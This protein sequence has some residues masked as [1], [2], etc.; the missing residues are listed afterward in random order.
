[1]IPKSEF[2]LIEWSEPQRP[3]TRC[4]AANLAGDRV[5]VIE[6]LS[7]G[8]L[9]HEHRSFG[10]TMKTYDKWGLFDVIPEYVTLPLCHSRIGDQ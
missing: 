5:P 1:M 2:K 3:L 6:D 8:L 9:T 10:D 7:V 4:Q